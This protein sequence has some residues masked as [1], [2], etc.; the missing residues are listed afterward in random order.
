MMD[1]KLKIKQIVARQMNLDEDSFDGCDL[2]IVNDL[3]AD[4]L[5]VVEI[6]VTVESTFGV[7]V[8]D[9]DIPSIRT[10]NDIVSYIENTR[11]WHENT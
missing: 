7:D 1:I 3:G 6:L 5:D 10:V 9:E 4:S 11:H 8:P 2:D